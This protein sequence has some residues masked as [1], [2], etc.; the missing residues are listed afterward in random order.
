MGSFL[1]S[2][3]DTGL[4]IVG[5]VVGA[6]GEEDSDPKATPTSPSTVSGEVRKNVDILFDET[7]MEAMT[8]LTK[9]M[10][11]WGDIDRN[12]F[13][14][15][16][17]PFQESLISTNQQLLPMIGQ[18][19]NLSLEQNIKDLTGSD[20]LKTIFRNNISDLGGQ[21]SDT[22]K[23]FGAELDNLPSVQERVGQAVSAVEQQFGQAGQDI[24]RR[25]AAQGLNV[26]EATERDLA[27]KKATAKAGAVGAASEAARRER[28]DALAQGAGVFSNLQASQAGLLANQQQLT[29]Q[30]VGLTPQVAGVQAT[31][32]VSEAGGLAKDLTG[33]A[34][35][36]ARGTSETGRD[37]SV[38][39]AGATSGAFPGLD[40]GRLF[41]EA[42]NLT[43]I[44]SALEGKL[45]TAELQGLREAEANRFS[46]GT[47]SD[48][49]SA[50]GFGSGQIQQTLDAKYPGIMDK[51]KEVA[52]SLIGTGVGLF[53]GPIGA[54]AAKYGADKV[55]N[56]TREGGA[57]AGGGGH[58]VGGAKGT[59]TGTGGGFN[60][61]GGGVTGL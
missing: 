42:G 53:A 19:A 39:Q 12:F 58:N 55:I 20:A 10:E 54:A 15:T 59:S 24:R 9:K 40:G 56:P 1:D 7:A 60:T 8:N 31:G 3:I 45:T 32:A 33:A 49:I 36:L 23:R 14:E 17:R 61:G 4:D 37:I 27:I 25:L 41:D 43:P 18:N 57:G 28:T 38:T 13:E 30:G 29:Q 50:P 11:E 48:P 47:G 22:A 26:S 44:G 35:L 34:G 16:Y 46:A 5:G 6:L 21:M 51:I 52:P 2:I